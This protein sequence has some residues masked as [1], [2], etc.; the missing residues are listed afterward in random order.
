MYNAAVPFIKVRM[1]V[2]A[3]RGRPEVQGRGSPEGADS[4][5]EE[6]LC[7]RSLT[8]IRLRATDRGVF[9]GCEHRICNVG[10]NN[11]NKKKAI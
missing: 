3:E 9:L 5:E 1:S 6:A 7:D 2:K 8:Q 4:S 10:F 11:K